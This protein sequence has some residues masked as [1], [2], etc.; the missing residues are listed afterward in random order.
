MTSGPIEPSADIRAF[1]LHMRQVYLAL[2]G[3]GFTEPQAMAIIGT[4]IAAAI[5][6]GQQ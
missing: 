2:V 4:T 1:A 6:R 5:T 3:Q